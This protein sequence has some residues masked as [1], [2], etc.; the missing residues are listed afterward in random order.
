[1][2][3]VDARQVG[4][5]ERHRR[6]RRAVPGHELDDRAVGP[7]RRRS[8]VAPAGIGRLTGVP[9]WTASVGAAEPPSSS[10]VRFASR[11]GN[12]TWSGRS[13]RRGSKARTAVGSPAA[14]AGVEQGSAL[15]ARDDGP[16]PV[17]QRRAA[18]PRRC[19]SSTGRRSAGSARPGR[20]SRCPGS[21][22][23]RSTSPS[24]AR[25]RRR[26]GQDRRSSAASPGS[27]AL[28]D[29][30]GPTAGRPC[31]RSAGRTRSGVTPNSSTF[32]R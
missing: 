13:D 19:G 8:P 30:R 25:R 22:A 6:P 31:A 32:G 26:D 16:R 4:P 24:G 3:D 20:A 11:I 27:V 23:C 15:R 18:T 2:T 1:M 29:D 21:S 9:G 5:G 14:D 17:G 28:E 10:P 7:R 12:A